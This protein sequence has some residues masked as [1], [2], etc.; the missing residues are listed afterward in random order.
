LPGTDRRLL[1]LGFALE[2]ALGPI[3]PP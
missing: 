2:R 3:P 1:A